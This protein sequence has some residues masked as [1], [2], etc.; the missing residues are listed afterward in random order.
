LRF[1]VVIQTPKDPQSAIYIGYQL[2]AATLERMHHTVTIFGPRDFPTSARFGGR[3]TPLTYPLSVAAWLRTHADDFDLVMFHSYSGWLAT[4]LNRRRPRALVMFH[5]VEP[6]YHRELRIE[7]ERSG[8][9]LSWRYRALQEL[10]MP[11]FLKIACRS[12]AGVTCLNRDEAAYL[13]AVGWACDGAVHV[14]A[15]GVPREFCVPARSLRPL[16][17]LLFVGQ[18][19]PMKGI[20]YLQEAVLALLTDDDHMRVVVAGTLAGAEHVQAEFPTTIRNRIQVLP[21]VD[22][23]ALAR[24]YQEADIFV[25]P[26]LYE[27]FSRAILEAMAARLPIVCTNVGVAA[28]ALRHEHNALIVPKRDA[29]AIVAAVQRLKEDPL[30]AHRLAAAAAEAAGHYTLDAVSERTVD[31]IMNVARR[32]Q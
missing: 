32:T 3:W 19:L 4:V 1:A 29:P 6:L 12:A 17:T 16:R 28:D 11:M 8:G 13:K 30:L 7:T 2:L 15:H 14:L 26:S 5:G 9:H 21:R 22:Q 23:L 10:L 24:L 20:R 31:V 18:W 25:F 27:G